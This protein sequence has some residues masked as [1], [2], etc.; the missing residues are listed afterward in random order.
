MLRYAC[1]KEELSCIIG[2]LFAELRPPCAACRRGQLVICGT[3]VTGGEAT[4]IVTEFGFDY[5][6]DPDLIN[7]IRQRRCNNEQAREPTAQRT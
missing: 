7:T 4:L 1:T 2:N 5:N 3:T 6:G